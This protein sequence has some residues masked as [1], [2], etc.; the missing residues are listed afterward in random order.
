MRS[1]QM[2]ELSRIMTTFRGVICR[3]TCF[4]SGSQC[5]VCGQHQWLVDVASYLPVHQVQFSMCVG[6]SQPP[7]LAFVQIVVHRS[8]K[9]SA[10]GIH[11]FRRTWQ[12]LK[13][14]HRLPSSIYIYTVEVISPKPC[15]GEP[16][17]ASSS[18][19]C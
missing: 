6:F 5:S 4:H 13:S 9:H 19:M 1:L 3:G 14:Q 8:C 11:L 15:Q 2:L 17:I 16:Q 10:L 7:I 18:T 12:Y